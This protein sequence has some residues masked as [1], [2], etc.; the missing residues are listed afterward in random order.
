MCCG[1]VLADGVDIHDGLCCC[2]SLFLFIGGVV[3]SAISD[4]YVREYAGVGEGANPV[5]SATPVVVNKRV[6]SFDVYI[7]RG[8]KWGN[9]FV[10]GKDGNREEVVAKYRVYL[11]GNKELLGSLYELGGKRLGCFCAPRSCHGD[12]LVRAWKYYCGE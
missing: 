7:G 9:P 3:M 11:A 6:E 4:V 8:S 12:I 2:V 1:I 10:M 5:G